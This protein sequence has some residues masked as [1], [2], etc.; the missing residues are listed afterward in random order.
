MGLPVIKQTML[1]FFSEIPNLE[2]YLNHCIGSK[3][4]AILINGCILPTGGVALGRVCPAACAAGLL[5]YIA[6]YIVPPRH[7]YID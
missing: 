5:L 7:N 2:R 6:Q 4:T 3:V 1:T